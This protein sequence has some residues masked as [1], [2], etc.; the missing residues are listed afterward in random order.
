MRARQ[1]A[2]ETVTWAL[3]VFAVGW[4]FGA[5]TA[6]FER[7]V[8]IDY[9]A[10][11]RR[12]IDLG[13]LLRGVA[14]LL[15]ALV[16]LVARP[17]LLGWSA[18]LSVGRLA[19][20]VVAVV[21]AVAFA[22]LV[23]HNHRFDDTSPVTRRDM[24]RATPD[25]LVGWRFVPSQRVSVDL[26]GRTVEYAIDADGARALSV[27]DRNDPG[28]PTIVLAGE[29]IAFGESLSWDDTL[30]ARLAADLH[31]QVVDVGVPAD[32]SDQT[33]LRVVEALARVRRPTAV[34][35]TFVLQVIRRN[36]QTT[37]PHLV[38]R[39][40]ALVPAPA[41]RGLAVARLWQDEPYHGDD[42]LE[43]TR[44]V[45]SATVRAARARGAM[46]LFVVTNFGPPCLDG[47]RARVF[48]DLFGD[49]QT[50]YVYVELGPD[51]TF[52]EPDFH[53]NALGARKLADAAAR[54][55]GARPQ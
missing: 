43:H 53:P 7:H 38:L 6:W 30:A 36:R 15:A 33:Y 40:G 12:A 26:H 54:V 2:V 47:E 16:A 4:A 20:F 10:E 52:A 39:A 17:R 22:E 27:A 19:S 21:A 25:P 3:V 14:L 51:E 34:V 31:A 11:S 48:G 24:P 45:L 50:P 8:F 13:Q 32:S 18:G 42:A 41:A 23:L 28:R 5:D 55:L 37:R 44:A 35:T 1:I 29:S 46:P 49:G 9:C